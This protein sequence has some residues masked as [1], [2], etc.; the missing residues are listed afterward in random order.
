MRCA[1]KRCAMWRKGASLENAS[2]DE[3]ERLRTI[4]A[5]VSG[6]L[7]SGVALLAIML[8]WPHTRWIGDVA[9]FL[10]PRQLVWVAL[11]NTVVLVGAYFAVA[12]LI[13]AFADATMPHPRT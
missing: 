3:R 4:A 10:S 6:V 9:D 8:A 1:A 11:A 13:W 5:V 12:A 7:I 2:P